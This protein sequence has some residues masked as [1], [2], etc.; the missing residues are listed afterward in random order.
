M[1]F[2]RLIIPSNSSIKVGA[3]GCIDWVTSIF[4]QEGLGVEFLMVLL[5]LASAL[6]VVRPPLFVPCP[7]GPLIVLSLIS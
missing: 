7:S 1:N 5:V 6:L 2:S 3:R 4:I